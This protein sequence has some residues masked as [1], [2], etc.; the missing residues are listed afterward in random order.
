MPQNGQQTIIFFIPVECEEE[1]SCQTAFAKRSESES[2]CEFYDG[3]ENRWGWNTLL[4]TDGGPYTFDVWAGA[5][6]CDTGKG[7]LVGTATL[8]FENGGVSVTTDFGDYTINVEHIYAGT[9][10]YPIKNGE[11]TL[12]PGKYYVEDLT[13][14]DEAYVIL[15]W[16]VCGEFDED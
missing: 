6:Q 5:G 14:E 4:D 1:P 3:K 10:P 11:P 15:H 7:V 13:N 9:T 2:F 12:A 16:E 8:S